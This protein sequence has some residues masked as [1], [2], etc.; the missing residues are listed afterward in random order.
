MVNDDKDNL[1]NLL[2]HYT[3]T[4]FNLMILK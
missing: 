4:L 1:V 2:I 3:L